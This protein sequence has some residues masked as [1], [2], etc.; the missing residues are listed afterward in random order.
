MDKSRELPPP[1][2]EQTQLRRRNAY[3]YGGEYE[4][5][6]VQHW[7]APEANRMRDQPCPRC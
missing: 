6:F 7:T 2:S 1:A 5:T 3:D 4:F